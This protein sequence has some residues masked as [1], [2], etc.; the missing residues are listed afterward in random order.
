[1]MLH[2]AALNR[3][4]HLTPQDSSKFRSLCSSICLLLLLICLYIKQSSAK[5]LTLKDTIDGRSFICKRKSI[6]PKT[7]PCGTP[8]STSTRLEDTP[9]TTTHCLPF[10]KI[11]NPLPNVFVYAVVL[12]FTE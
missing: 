12:E 7:V 10:F 5:S 9:S 11:R 8:E 3:I 4:P 1:M 2:L 6:G